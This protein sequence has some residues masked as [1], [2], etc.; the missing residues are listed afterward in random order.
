MTHIIPETVPVGY[1]FRLEDKRQVIYKSI[2]EYGA[3][4]GFEVEHIL[5]GP[6]YRD[7]VGRRIS[8]KT[9]LENLP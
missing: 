4:P 8:N 2:T 5:R 3:D 1:D 6:R 7:K 9:S